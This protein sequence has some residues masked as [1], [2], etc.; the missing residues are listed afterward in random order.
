VLRGVRNA[1]SL[2]HLWRRRKLELLPECT[3]AIQQATKPRMHRAVSA[4]WW[5]ASVTIR[6]CIVWHFWHPV[7]RHGETEHTNQV[8]QHGDTPNRRGR[9]PG[10]IQRVPSR[11][12]NASDVDG[13]CQRVRKYCLAGG[14]MNPQH[15]PGRRRGTPVSGQIC[16]REHV[17]GVQHKGR[18][19]VR[20][21]SSS[22]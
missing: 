15:G 12:H 4:Q 8:A 21:G 5:V 20:R 22:R 11:Q 10:R 9:V 17:R 2:Y 14:A 7:N 16:P 18:A 3:L 13:S 19:L 1:S 6:R